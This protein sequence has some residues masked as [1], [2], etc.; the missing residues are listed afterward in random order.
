[1]ERRDLRELD[2]N[3]LVV[4]ELLLRHR[5]TVLAARELGRTQSAVSHALRRLRDH[6]G[7]PLLVRVGNQLQPTPRAEALQAPL[8]QALDALGAVLDPHELRPET[9]RTTVRIMLADYM[10]AIA[11]PPLLALLADEAP[12][13]DVTCLYPGDALEPLLQSGEADFALGAQFRERAGLL[14]RP[15]YEDRMV[16][17]LR[18]GHPVRRMTMKRFL[19]AR[20]VLVTPRGNP[21]GIVDDRLAE[22]GLERRVALRTPS[23]HTALRVVAN[24]D[25]VTTLPERFARGAVESHGLRVLS[26][27]VE[28]AALRIGMLFSAS[29]R[30]DPALRWIRDA[31]IR[32]LQPEG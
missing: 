11:L 25:M 28:L 32:A 4:L 15:L 31:V 29:R 13:V 14:L 16:C 27:P 18:T 30:D 3:L 9:L 5:S 6:L 12:G 23:F 10:E 20:H 19:E 7:D 17:V 2:L 21:G 24:S 8:A 22:E 1:M 26:A